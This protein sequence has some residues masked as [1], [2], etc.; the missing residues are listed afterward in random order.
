LLFFLLLVFLFLYLIGERVNRL[1]GL[2]KSLHVDDIFSGKLLTEVGS[3]L[4][5]TVISVKVVLLWL[6]KQYLLKV[7]KTGV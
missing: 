4:L 7:F 3:Y 5:D 1:L 6:F 2:S